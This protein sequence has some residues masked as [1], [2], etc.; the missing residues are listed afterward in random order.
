MNGHQT[1]QRNQFLTKFKYKGRVL[2]NL[3]KCNGRDEHFKL[4]PSAY[5]LDRNHLEAQNNY[6]FVMNK[7]NCL[8]NLLHFES[9][10]NSRSKY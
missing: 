1:W 10:Y 2:A 6:C 8:K 3:N 4:V 7:T 9:F 5:S